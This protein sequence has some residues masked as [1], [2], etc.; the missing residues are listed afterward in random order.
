MYKIGDLVVYEGSNCICRVSD[1]APLDF[2]GADNSRLYYVLKPLHQDCVMYNPVDNTNA[3]MR[4]V[5]TKDE[6]EKLIDAIPEM[7]ELETVENG[8]T[9][10]SFQQNKQSVQRY[11]SIMKTRDCANLIKL[12]MFLHRKKDFQAKIDRNIGSV[13]NT[14]MKRA[15]GMLFDELSI[16]LD[17]PKESVPQ[18]IEN[19]ISGKMEAKWN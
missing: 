3:L 17:I 11:E 16:A 6:A 9:T 13:D 1:I 8:G 14:T 18:Y 2:Q 19:R 5:I 15:E 4:L 10:H 12:T 7:E